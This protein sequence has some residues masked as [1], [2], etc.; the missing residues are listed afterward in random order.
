VSIRLS[1]LGKIQPTHHSGASD[2]GHMEVISSNMYILFEAPDTGFDDARMANAFGS[3]RAS[4]PGRQDRASG[5]RDGERGCRG[6]R[7]RTRQRST[8]GSFVEDQS[9][10]GEG[11]HWLIED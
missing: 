10:F 9:G 7:V 5:L 6:K 1:A 8:R 4:I 11:C 3:D 2:L